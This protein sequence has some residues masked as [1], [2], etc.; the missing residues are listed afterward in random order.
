MS[1]LMKK[2]LE[3]ADQMDANATVIRREAARE[4]RRQGKTFAEIA[5]ALGISR[6]RAH[7]LCT[8][9]EPTVEVSA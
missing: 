7:Q 5:E 2:L 8:E 9:G 3:V 4:L 6:A 1:A